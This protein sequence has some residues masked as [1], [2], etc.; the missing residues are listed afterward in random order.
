MS[1]LACAQDLLLCMG[2]EFV[3]LQVPQ[4]CTKEET[5]LSVQGTLDIKQNALPNVDPCASEAPLLPRV[6]EI[7]RSISTLGKVC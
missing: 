6:V 1:P 3:Y 2:S 5:T 7:S 4:Q